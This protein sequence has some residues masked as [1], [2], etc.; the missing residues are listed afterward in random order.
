IVTFCHGEFLMVALYLTYLAVT[1]LGL[2]S[3]VSIVIVVP[4]MLLFAAAVYFLFIEPILA[5]NEH[6]QIVT[7][8][9]LGLILQNV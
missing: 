4:L 6:N 7:T 8:L 9:A 2:N 1:W 5:S 3:Y